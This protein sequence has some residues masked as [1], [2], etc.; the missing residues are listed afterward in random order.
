MDW[1]KRILIQLDEHLE[2]LLLIA[3]SDGLISSDENIIAEID[4]RGYDIILF[5]DSISVRYT[6]ELKYRIEK[7]L[8][9][10]SGT[11]KHPKLAILFPGPPDQ[12]VKKIPFDIVNASIGRGGKIISVTIPEIF[13]NLSYPILEKVETRYFDKLYESYLNYDGPRLGDKQTKEY[14]LNN[15]FEINVYNI[16]TSSK[17]LVRI[18]LSMHY[19]SVILPS[20]L[21]DYIIEVLSK[22][23]KFDDWPL[24]EI[25][26]NS[27]Q[28]FNFIQCEWESYLQ[29]L[30]EQIKQRPSKLGKVPFEHRDIRVYIDNLF[31]EGYLKPIVIDQNHK[32]FPDWT[33][34]GILVDEAKY[35]LASIQ[36]LVSNMELD[37][38][39]EDAS[40]V[41]WQKFAFYWSKLLVLR[42][43]N[44]NI[45][46]KD[47]D[48]R[49]ER[50]H[51]L[52][53]ERFMKWMFSKYFALSNLPY[54]PQP[55][56]VH[57][58]PKFLTYQYK[59]E[60]SNINTKKKI[61]LIVVDG[62]SLDLWLII[63]DAIN[64]E[65]INTVE[66]SI[67][68]WV[69]TLTNISRQS[70]F[71]GEPPFYFEESLHRTDQDEK[72]WRNHWQDAG[73][74]TEQILYNKGYMLYDEKEINE[75]I[76]NAEDKKI[77]GI[78][79][80]AIDKII[81][82]MTLGTAGMHHQVQMWVKQGLFTRLL[83]QL[84][85]EGFSIYITSDHGNISSLGQGRPRQGILVD[86]SGARVRIYDN[87][88]FLNQGHSQFPIT[89]IVWSN[90]GMLEHYFLLS[91]GRLVFAKKGERLV[92]HGGISVEEVLVPFILLVKG[93]N[94]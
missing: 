29:L 55:I 49:F 2:E 42:F 43:N 5:E 39:A 91:T 47:L 51:D 25:V 59:K 69:P 17:E 48:E 85:D 35:L 11:I 73:F 54:I 10:S 81:H 78:V 57:Q 60:T 72:H 66:S 16:A 40:Y 92:S 90:S 87:K 88:T 56:L 44:S 68:A 71:A 63:K 18:L 8:S 82:G 33:H 38:P 1:R 45:I 94:L 76:S 50:L 74:R 12:A 65:G 6:Y 4:R 84:I 28:F 15:I 79:I 70:I 26:Q 19:R 30:S 89:S 36:K 37:L 14:L 93:N 53:E 61:A 24:R 27:D 9:L 20:I 32:Q 23:G 77:I 83:Q 3:D 67:F 80:N 52:V 58:I 21:S 22:T 41:S 13:P 62:M 7:L 75:I 86:S 34:S 46:Q 31:A 64:A